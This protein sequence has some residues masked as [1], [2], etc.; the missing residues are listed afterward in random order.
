M[1]KP[2]IEPSKHL[3]HNSTRNYNLLSDFLVKLCE[4]L[5]EGF[6]DMYNSETLIG[7][8]SLKT[9]KRQHDKGMYNPI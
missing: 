2:A 9:T 5:V 8:L 3:D 7:F 6:K 4:P 1:C